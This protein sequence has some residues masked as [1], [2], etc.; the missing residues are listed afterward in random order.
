M[1]ASRTL[2]VFLGLGLVAASQS[3][4]LVRLADAH[5]V[6]IVA[7]RLALATLM[8][9]PLAGGRL[10]A[11]R[12]LGRGDLALLGLAGLALA[13]HLVTWVAAVQHTTVAN[14]AIFFSVNPV[15]TALA[16]Y[17]FLGERLDRR[18]V[19]GVALGLTGILVIG[20][21]DL[22]F[23]REHLVGDGLAVACA[24]LFTAYFLLGRRV[25]Q[26]LDNRVYVTALY[27]VAAACAVV[28]A[29]AG[30]LPLRGFDGRT[31]LAFLLLALVPT[32]IGHT[33][34]NYALRYLE[35]GR[36]S[37]LTLSEPLFAGIVAYFAWGE[38]IPPRT[39]LGYVLVCAGVLAVLAAGSRP[40]EGVAEPVKTAKLR[41]SGER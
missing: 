26:R 33:A 2:V 12:T 14:A 17:L 5:P 15:T 39:A 19:V 31:W 24:L 32:M 40:A 29:A 27:G 30:G 7:Y 11:V 3:G 4:N 20:A 10:A 41:A 6:V 34:L 18:V 8:L 1:A 25:R 28:G 16:G 38:R 23:G 13:G 22:R 21:G 37:A 36:V 9:A 35:A